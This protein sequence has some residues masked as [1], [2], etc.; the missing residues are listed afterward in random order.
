[1]ITVTLAEAAI[2]RHSAKESTIVTE[3]HSLGVLVREEYTYPGF[4][5]GEYSGNFDGG[6]YSDQ[7]VHSAHLAACE[8]LM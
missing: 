5:G 7:L 8:W 2:L 6:D 3:E 1:M 4:K